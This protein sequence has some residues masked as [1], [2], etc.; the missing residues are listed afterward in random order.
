M[1][2]VILLINL[3][4]CI[5]LRADINAFVLSR[6]PNH[7]LVLTGIT[8][9]DVFG[10]AFMINAQSHAFSEICALEENPILVEHAQYPIRYY[11]SRFKPSLKSYSVHCARSVT[12]LASFIKSINTPITFVLASQFPDWTV[13]D[14]QNLILQELDQIKQHYIKGHT[15]LVDYIYF[16]NVGVE[17]IKNKLLEINSDYEFSLE[18]GGHLA[19][20]ENAILA[21]RPKKAS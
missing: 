21:A 2:K 19:R 18:T 9:S 5:V 3:L 12:D 10:Y 14:K 15:I 7:V 20:E 16:G 13:P 6:F 17:A 11:S 4:T 1:K 8:N